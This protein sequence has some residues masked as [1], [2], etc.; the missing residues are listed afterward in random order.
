MLAFSPPSSFLLPPYAIATFS[1]AFGFFAAVSYDIMMMPA[2]DLLRLML[3][4]FLRAVD[5]RHAF[6]PFFFFVYAMMLAASSSF[7]S[8]LFSPSLLCRMPYSLLRFLRLSVLGRLQ[9][10]S[11]RYLFSPPLLLL[12]ISLML[13]DYTLFRFICLRRV[14]R[15]FFSL[16]LMMPLVLRRYFALCCHSRADIARH[17]RYAMALRCCPLA[18]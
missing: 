3:A 15:Y 18:F 2:A 9:M 4:D 8:L 1:A 13:S 7:S 12:I 16:R 6:A 10:F 11:V 14:A 5:F 17:E